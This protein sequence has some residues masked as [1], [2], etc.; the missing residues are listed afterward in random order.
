M[1][2]G[3]A[4]A[5]IVWHHLAF[6]G[7]MSDIAQPLASALI[8][9][10]YDYG[11]MAVQVFLVLGGY[12][13]AASL[14][15]DGVARFDHAGTAAA[16]RFVRLVLPYTVA[17]VLTVLVAAFVRPWFDHSS[18]PDDPTFA[19][20]VANALLLQDVLGESALSAGVWY[21]A[22]DFQLFVLSVL[23]WSGVRALPGAWARRHAAALGRGAVMAGVAASLWMFNRM[24]WL[25]MWALYFLGS[26]G[27]GMMACW[28]VRSPRPTAWVAAMVLLG[29]IAL[30]LDFRGRIAVALATALFLVAALQ[31]E[32]VRAWRG[33][34][35]LVRLGQMSYS[36]F[37]V[38]FAVCL[39]ANA[40][41]SRLWPTS[42]AL[43][44]LGMVLAFGLSLAAGRQLY[45][46]VERHVP[47]AVMAVRWQLG[48]VGTGLLVALVNNWG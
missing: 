9:W 19:Q 45:L 26:Y 33:I 28:A 5:T 35:P 21:V 47:S 16:R 42:P 15:P 8:D 40:V 22:I 31:S 29:G 38:H 25:D 32:R 48:L 23:L 14:A 2:K 24:P 44:A 30:A 27:L 37:L 3:L 7:P 12:L 6:Y 46:R 10:L 11:R 20:L 34:G 13:A 17:L 1:A 39:L 36:V 18:V 41:A 43:N 4:C